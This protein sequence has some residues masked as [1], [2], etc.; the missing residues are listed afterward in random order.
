MKG[1]R[2]AG[3]ARRDTEWSGLRRLESVT[4][5]TAKSLWTELMAAEGPVILITFL[6]RCINPAHS[7][8]SAAESVPGHFK[9]HEVCRRK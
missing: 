6:R 3:C 7:C 8:V 5:G 4:V 1:R 2:A 9:I